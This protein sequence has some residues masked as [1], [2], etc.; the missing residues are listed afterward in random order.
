MIVVVTRNVP[1]KIRGF[2]ASCML[3]VTPA[4]YASPSMTR[5]VR[6]RTWSV[7]SKW[8]V[9]I[10]DSSLVMIYKDNTE[11]TGVGILSLGETPRRI[12]DADGVALSYL[13]K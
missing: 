9:D 11:A 2:L 1:D 5:G 6:D 3:E 8:F 4:V 13:S 7:L 12:I 10:S